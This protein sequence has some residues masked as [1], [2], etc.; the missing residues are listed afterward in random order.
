MK[1]G[2]VMQHEREFEL[3]IVDSL[4]SYP[5]REERDGIAAA[6][7]ITTPAEALEALKAT[8]GASAVMKHLQSRESDALAA[9]RLLQ[10]MSEDR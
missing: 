8:K 2:D 9:D 6:E 4:E 5:V 3:T 1:G 7:L 10:R